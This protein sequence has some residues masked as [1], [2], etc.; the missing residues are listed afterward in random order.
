M[1]A[2]DEYH[3]HMA[4]LDNGNGGEH[5][6]LAAA[7]EGERDEAGGEKPVPAVPVQQQEG[8]KE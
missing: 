3:M 1:A 7:K 8:G 2:L 5:R 6:A 4:A